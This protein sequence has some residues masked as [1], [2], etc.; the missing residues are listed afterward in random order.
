VA[1]ETEL[2]AL[3]RRF[4]IM[5]QSALGI[6]LLTR[7]LEVVWLGRPVQDVLDIYP[8]ITSAVLVPR[9][10]EV[11]FTCNDAGTAHRVLV[12]NYVEKK[13]SVSR[14]LPVANITIADAC[15]WNDQWCFLSAGGAVYVEAEADFKDNGTYVPMILET[16]WVSASGPLAFQSVREFQLGGISNSNHDLVVDVA[17]D[18]ESTYA[19]SRTFL[20]GSA[21][22]SIGDLE[23]CTIAIGT[24]RKCQSIRFR[25]SDATPTNPGSFPVGT[26]RGPSFDAMGL[27]VGVKRGFHVNP[28][29]KRG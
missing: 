19:Q 8:K 25:I 3:R 27:A 6:S 5:F 4:G 11:R 26:G 16:A 9:R 2:D 18:S 28:A 14:Y 13:W 23:E 17:F 12:W 24:R 21:V 1:G 15:I 10:N 7:G 29:T 20:A 22:T